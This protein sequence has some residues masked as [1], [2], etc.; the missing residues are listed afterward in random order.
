MF[1]FLEK[2]SYKLRPDALNL[3][4]VEQKKLEAH[5]LKYPIIY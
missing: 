4:E 5:T 1:Q 2:C 3:I